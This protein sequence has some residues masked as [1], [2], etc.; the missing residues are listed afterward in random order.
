M[1][2]YALLPII[3]VTLSNVFYNICAKE[4]PHGVNP[5]ASLAVTYVVAA[6][7]CIALFY[8]TADQSSLTKELTKINWATPLLAA[9]IVGLEFGYIL[10]YRAGWPINIGSLVTNIA[11]ALILLVIGT[12][13]YHENFSIQKVLGFFLCSGGL[14]LLLR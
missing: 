3:I 1:I 2:R 5:F 9:C 6:A 13:F 8:A 11:L 12:L 4:T 10:L 14:A 7:L